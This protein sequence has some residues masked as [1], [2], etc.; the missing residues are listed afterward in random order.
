MKKL[1]FILCFSFL[2]S[3][4]SSDQVSNNKIPTNSDPVNWLTIHEKRYDYTSI[5]HDMD[6]TTLI[7]TETVT[8]SD[9]GMEHGHKIYKSKVYEDSYFT[10]SPDYENAWREYKLR[11]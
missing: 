8:D 10:K 7:D 3:G 6:E 9:D 5:H 2:L 11:E 4:C 1:M